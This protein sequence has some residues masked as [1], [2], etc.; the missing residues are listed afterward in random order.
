MKPTWELSK[1]SQVAEISAGNP[2]P[3]RKVQFQNGTYPFFRTSDVGEIHIGRINKSRDYLNNNGIQ[4]MRLFKKGTIL[5]PKSGASTFLNH[6]VIMDIDG[7][8]S[9][10]L[11]TI[12]AYETKIDNTFLFY[13]LMEINAK[14]LIQDSKYPSLNLNVIKD[15]EIPL[16]PLPEQRRIVAILDQA[17][18]AI[19]K[20]KENTEKNLQNARELFQSTLN[21]VF[22]NPDSG[23]GEKKLKNICLIR[24]PKS[25]VRQKLGDNDLVS[26]VP[27][28]DLGICQKNFPISRS[29]PLKEVFGSYTYF[30][31]EDVLLAK[32]T[33]C[34]ENGK[35]G[36]A[37]N[38][39]NNFG[40]GSS[41]YFVFRTNE[42]L[43]NEYLFYFL[44]RE[45]FRIE[46]AQ[47]MSGAVGHKRV[48]KDFIE[49]YLISLPP[50]PEQRSIVFK[51]DNLTA[52][53]QKQEI[54]QC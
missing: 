47:N 36:I 43:F 54:I 37:R 20:A 15:I 33:P 50:L 52:E 28:E 16:P 32:I 34:F 35:L 19:A 42:Y 5:F 38:L 9:S 17:F 10:H 39:T 30:A 51:L 13:Y 41:E 7:F 18:E 29:R 46:G 14:H 53:I 8:V 26:F 3:Q 22:S 21:K 45:K 27:M 25:E 2:A 24:P 12:C 6:R 48:A 40:F 49:N 31:E 1:L 23:W 4:G 11:A 44:S